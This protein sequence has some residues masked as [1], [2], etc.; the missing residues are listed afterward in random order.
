MMNIITLLLSQSCVSY[1]KNIDIIFIA[2]PLTVS[3]SC[4]IFDTKMA[5]SG[6]SGSFELLLFISRGAKI[7]LGGGG[8]GERPPTPLNAPL[9][10]DSWLSRACFLIV[11]ELS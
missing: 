7:Y 1:C 11:Q 3:T 4:V 5:R 6:L 8:G 10:F 9:P 2:L